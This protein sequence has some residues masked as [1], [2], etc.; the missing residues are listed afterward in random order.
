MQVWCRSQFAQMQK[1]LIEFWKF[2]TKFGVSLNNIT[3][4]LFFPLEYFHERI[5][6]ILLEGHLNS[7]FFEKNIPDM[8]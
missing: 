7:I 8:Y 3:T 6:V 1:E 5:L 4:Y 2:L